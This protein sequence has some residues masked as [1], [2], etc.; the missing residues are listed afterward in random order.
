[1]PE[2]VLP[3]YFFQ[4]HE[5]VI[6][7]IYNGSEFLESAAAAIEVGIVMESTSFYAEQ[8]GQVCCSLDHLFEFFCWDMHGF[9]L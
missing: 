8:G 4:D 9:D 2:F 6:K 3:M 1:M 7:A 5:S